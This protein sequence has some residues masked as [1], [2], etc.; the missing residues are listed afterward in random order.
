MH[1]QKNQMATNIA[2]RHTVPS[3]DNTF[4]N[5]VHQVIFQGGGSNTQKNSLSFLV[6]FFSV[7]VILLLMRPKVVVYRK[8]DDVP[9]F[10]H[11]AAFLWSLF[12]GGA[13][14]GLL[15]VNW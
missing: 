8:D 13:C 2:W 4:Q 14:L 9:R 10:R 1:K 11:G 7:Y 3:V 5:T 15:H 12:A 6:T